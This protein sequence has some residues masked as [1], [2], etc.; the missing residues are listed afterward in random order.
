MD[1]DAFDVH[2]N[3]TCTPARHFSGSGFTK[4]NIVGFVSIETGGLTIFIG[5][6]SGYHDSFKKI[7][8]PYGPFD[9]VMLDCGQYDVQ[10]PSI[11]MMPEQT[12]Q[13]SIDLKA[14]VLLPVHWGKF[15]LALHP[16]RKILFVGQRKRPRNSMSA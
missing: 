16:W 15:R 8:D 1:T 11:H 9:M 4:D 3:L 7:G 10:W 12:V 13:A 5:G 6:D 14:K 2:L